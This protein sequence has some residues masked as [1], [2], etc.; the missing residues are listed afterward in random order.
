M[1]FCESSDGLPLKPELSLLLACARAG[2]AQEK[3][4]AIEQL[5]AD[6]IDW[7][8][9]AQKALGHG[10]ATFAAHSLARLAPDSIP[11]DILDAFHALM[12]ETSRANRALFEELARLVDAL[13]KHGIE[14]IPFKGPLLAIQAFGDLG[15]R[16]FRDLDFLV[17]DEDLAKT[18]ATLH[19]LGYQRRRELTDAQFALIH[20]LQGQE[21]IFGEFSRTAVEPHTRVTSLKMALDIDYAG[22]WRRAQRTSVNGHTFLTPAPEDSLLLLAIHGGKEMWRKLKWACDLAGF[23][24]S[25]PDLDWATIAERARTQGCL[26]MLLLA[27]S[28]GR[29]YFNATIPDAIITA[30]RGDPTIE[31][32]VHRIVEQW[33]ADGPGL[34]RDGKLVDPGDKLIDM[35]W[36]R[37]HDGI[38]RQARYVARTLFLPGPEYVASIALPRHLDFAYIPIKLAHDL[39]ALP[40]W[41]AFRQAL[42]PVGRL[43]YAFGTSEVALAVIPASSE[44]KQTIR[45][46]RRARADA[47]RTLAR[48]PNDPAA[49]RDLGDALVG[50]R[51]HRD[52]IACYDRALANSPHDTTIW[53]KRL[54]AM[55]ATGAAID[56]PDYPHDPQDAQAWAIYAA[57]LFSSRRY[58]Q[59]IEASEC[60][61]ALDP[62]SVAAARVGIQARL[63]TCDWRRREADERRVSEEVEAGRRIVTPFF[64]RAISN[65]EAESLALARLSTRGL[66][67]P[68]VALCGGERYAHDKIRVAYSSTDFRDHVLSDA[69]AG[70]F[71]HHDRSR[72]Q[73]TAI[74]LGPDD[75]S[76]MR[77]RIAAAF[78]RFIDVQAMS[79]FEVAKLLR[80]LEIDI[81]VDLNGNS[82]DCR[83]G[84]FTHRPAPVQVSFLGYPGT[85]GLPFFEYIIADPVVIPHGQR[86]HYTEQVVYM[87]HTYMPNDRTRH[88]LVKAPSRTDAGLPTTGFVFACHN[89]EY[90]ITPEVFDTWMRLLKTVDGSILWLKS[91][92]PSAIVNLRRE[93]NARGVA[94]ERLVFAPRL[95]Q[96]K[97]H[98]ARL[99]LADLFL[100]TRPYNA[101]ASACDA[102]WAG[103][104]VVTCLGNTFP[105]RVAASVLHA[106]GLPELVTASLAEY[107]GLAAALALDRDRLATIKAKLMR[108]RVTEP[109]F[110]TRRFTRDLESAYMIM[111]KRQQDGL[112][113]ASF[114]VDC[115]P[116]R[117]A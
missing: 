50:L 94:P 103:V 59:A 45:R 7:T 112:P 58:A 41:Q 76:L 10:F 77:R 12:D 17:R 89:S 79:D 95:T 32:M 26:R 98:L 16:E 67:R 28:L 93:A 20:R 15:L 34:S 66:K 64:H 56:L 6:G 21:I 107:E 97:D 73:T 108:K 63:W 116:A 90:K 31:P 42:A 114:A 5:L 113:A 33:Q 54:T 25:F 92:N 39:M 48:V 51:R 43:P 82:G 104:P 36:L 99:Q 37:L 13:A 80:E 44:A 69:M 3:Q 57:R 87:P 29:K 100:D 19:S 86:I 8:S 4:A 40:L 27:T 62:D 47:K 61:I 14:A 75:G 102:L 35:D 78:D 101:H 110:D 11:G 81:V 55:Q 115:T 49:L 85:M 46:Y 88:I 83:T 53:K 23:V 117:A 71:E 18:I 109:L 72:F 22:L 74:S 65:S 9:F 60:S 24:G 96:A 84:I 52:A 91:P 106:I 105:G 30:E 1:K 111:W 2:K 68:T 38:A 70:C